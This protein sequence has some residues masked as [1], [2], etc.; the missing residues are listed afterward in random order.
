M[1]LLVN[2]WKI[3]LGRDGSLERR[4]GFVFWVYDC[5]WVIIDVW[6]WFGGV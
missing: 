4:V 1:L 5:N 6:D 3:V 2:D